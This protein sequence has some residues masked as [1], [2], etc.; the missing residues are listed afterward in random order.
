MSLPRLIFLFHV[1]SSDFGT[2]ASASLRLHRGEDSRNAL[3]VFLH[4]TGTET[5]FFVE[6]FGLKGPVL[7]DEFLYKMVFSRVSR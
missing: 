3:S 5:W 1:L 2:S 7:V 4:H 6:S